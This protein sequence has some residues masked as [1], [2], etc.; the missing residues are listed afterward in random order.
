MT[1]RLPRALLLA[2][3]A[4][5]SA[6]E[7]P[8][9]TWRSLVAPLAPGREVTRGYVLS[10]P[11]RGHERDVVF[12]AVRPSD[13]RAVEVHVV[14]RGQWTG[15]RETRSFGV[16]W[17]EP[18]SRAPRAD[19]EAV[20]QSLRDALARNDHG[21]GPVDAIPL[22]AARPITLRDRAVLAL[23]A[24][25]TRVPIPWWAV[26]VALCVAASWRRWKPAREAAV[27]AAVALVLRVAF[28]AWGPFHINQQGALWIDGALHPNALRAY[29]PGFAELY[30]LAAHVLAPDTAVFALNL[31]LGAAIAPLAMAVARRAGLSVGRS[32]VA[33]VVVAA[34]PVLVRIAATESYVTPVVALALASAWA[35]LA[36]VDA[37]LRDD[38]PRRLALAF[39]GALFAA[40]GVRVHP[41]GWIAAALIPLLVGAAAG[42]RVALRCAL[43]TGAVVLVTSGAVLADVLAALG[44]GTVMAP[45][46]RWRALA[47][48]VALGAVAALHPRTRSYAPATIASLTLGALVWETYGQSDV[49]RLAAVHVVLAAPLFAAVSALPEAPPRALAAAL[50]VVLFAAGV[51]MVRH[52]TTDAREYAWARR[53]LASR[54]PACRV[55]WVAFAGDR[56][57]VFLPTWA[58]RGTAVALDARAPLDVAARIAP[59]GCTFYL[60]SAACAS[61][62]GAAACADVERALVLAPESEAIFPAVASHRGLPYAGAT[63]RVATYRVLGLRTTEP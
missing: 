29:G 45:S 54:P 40:Q 10:A 7:P 43:T 49:W 59:L 24:L 22:D 12:R 50:G 33:G 26:A 62:D 48:G 34:D 52:R 13:G 36:A 9:D 4:G 37:P 2:A 15:V 21:L 46:L 5:C 18:R 58:H 17:E 53:W 38:R 35:W 16:A 60:R 11:V 3:L 28:G 14:A 1:R 19:L 51:P 39:A 27:V 32:L 63:V 25:G 47:V 55:V 20:T 23:R 42:W 6:R 30:G 31:A 56:R 44:G 57:T 41:L 8:P 61:A